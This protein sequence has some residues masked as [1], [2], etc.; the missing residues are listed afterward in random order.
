MT[1]PE[2][3]NER[4][5]GTAIDVLAQR[6]AQIRKDFIGM[7]TW[8]LKDRLHAQRDAKLA[9]P[10]GETL[11]FWLK[12]TNQPVGAEGVEPQPTMSFQVEGPP[13][14]EGYPRLRVHVPVPEGFRSDLESDIDA[15]PLPTAV[16]P[17]RLVKGRSAMIAVLGRFAVTNEDCRVYPIDQANP[18]AGPDLWVPTTQGLR[19]E[20]HL[21][22]LA[23]MVEDLIDWNLIAQ[24]STVI[25]QGAVIDL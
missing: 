1:T 2:E 19:V 8:V 21:P 4:F 20:T 7:S 23:Q 24:S 5:N 12:S 15:L 17:E 18:E 25:G 22:A 16:F 9:T 3:F 6:T 13:V 14:A 11:Q 10:V